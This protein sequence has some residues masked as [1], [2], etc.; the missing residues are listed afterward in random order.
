MF[1]QGGVKKVGRGKLARTG[2]KGIPSHGGDKE[3]GNFGA[4]KFKGGVGG[5]E[6]ID[7]SPINNF[8]DR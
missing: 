6:M 4:G 1:G 5:T 7:S 2:Y 3:G 8:G